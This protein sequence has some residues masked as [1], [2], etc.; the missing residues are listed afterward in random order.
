MKTITLAV[1]DGD[2]GSF[3]TALQLELGMNPI[4]ILRTTSLELLCATTN[5]F[6]FPQEHIK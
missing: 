5:Q 1:I 3:C 6:T 2:P 4:L